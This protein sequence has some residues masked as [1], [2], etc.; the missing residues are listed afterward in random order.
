MKMRVASAVLLVLVIA[1]AGY[2]QEPKILAKLDFA[3]MV[4]NKALPAGDYQFIRDE[5]ATAFRVTDGK[6]DHALLPVI[7]RVAR[8]PLGNMPDSYLVFDV[9][10]DKYILSEIWLPG[11]DGY[12]VAT[13][14]EL[15]THKVVPAK[16]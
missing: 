1:A 11:D 3:F 15:H 2:G 4:G 8:S 12:L 5:A 9:V 7:T 6:K 13:T 16:R 10:S 14:K